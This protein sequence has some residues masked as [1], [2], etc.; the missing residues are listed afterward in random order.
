MLVMQKNKNKKRKEIYV[1]GTRDERSS[2]MFQIPKSCDHV[3]N[4]MSTLTSLFVSNHQVCHFLYI[5]FIFLIKYYEAH[6]GPQ[7]PRR[8]TQAHEEETGPKR[9]RRASFG[10]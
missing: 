8:P 3:D 2:K 5:L 9:R 6:E 1:P 7:Q 4:F 10:P